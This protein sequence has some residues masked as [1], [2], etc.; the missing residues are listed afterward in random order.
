M[1]HDMTQ[2]RLVAVELAGKGEPVVTKVILEA[3]LA[4]T[5]VADLVKLHTPESG[6]PEDGVISL[7]TPLVDFALRYPYEGCLLMVALYPLAGGLYLYQECEVVE[8]YI[9]HL[10][11]EGLEAVLRHFAANAADPY[12]QKKYLQWAD[13]IAE[14]ATK[15]Q[16]DQT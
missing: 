15:N 2:A 11:P 8:A 10:H 16:P 3:G 13:C 7:M 9:D 1:H 5:V 12:M 6:R 4:E 14:S